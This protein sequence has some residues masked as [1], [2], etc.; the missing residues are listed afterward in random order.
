MTITGGTDGPT[1]LALSGTLA[2]GYNGTTINGSTGL[3]DSNVVISGP[4]TSSGTVNL[5]TAYTGATGGN[6][7]LT[8]SGAGTIIGT[9]VNVGA[10]AETS[11]TFNT[12]TF[13]SPVIATTG[14]ITINTDATDAA[15]GGVDN[16][17]I[18]AP[19]SAVNGHRHDHQRRHGDRELQHPAL[20]R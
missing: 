6:Y 7:N 20:G 14:G 3:G 17:V 11:G 10:V 18:A 4:I 19:F 5:A 15:H 9:S 2:S 13:N 16:L 8:T 1:F 12:F